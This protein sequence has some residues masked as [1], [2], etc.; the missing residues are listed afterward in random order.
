MALYVKPELK[1]Q[2]IGKAMFDYAKND[3]INKG[4]KKMILW[5]LKDNEPSRKFYEKM[6]GTIIRE[7]TIN[8]GGKSY[9]EVGFAYLF[10][11]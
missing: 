7:H 9:E 5:C 10:K 6:G 1:Y 4:N 2:G 11:N 8:I 3:L